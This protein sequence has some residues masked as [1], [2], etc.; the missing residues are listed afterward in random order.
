MVAD[1][2]VNLC[3]CGAL[4]APETLQ[5]ME[6]QGYYEGKISCYGNVLFRMFFPCGKGSKQAG[7]CGKSIRESQIR[8]KTHGIIVGIER[9]GKRILNPESHWILESDDIL[10]IAGDRKKINEFL[11]G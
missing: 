7:K 1:K 9:N 5:V 4:K 10:W 3:C 6:R 8:E 11:K 2:P